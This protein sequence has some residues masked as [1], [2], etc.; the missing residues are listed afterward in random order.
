MSTRAET[1]SLQQPKGYVRWVINADKLK[2]AD[3]PSPTLD[4][5]R[6]LSTTVDGQEVAVGVLAFPPQEP[7]AVGFW[8]K[9]AEK[10]GKKVS[11]KEELPPSRLRIEPPIDFD[12][13]KRGH[14][15]PI[16]ALHPYVV[17]EDGTTYALSVF[18]P[19]KWIE[20]EWSELKER[21][22]SGK[23][24]ESYEKL[25]TT[26]VYRQRNSVA[27]LVRLNGNIPLAERR[28]EA[29]NKNIPIRNEM[30]LG[31]NE[32]AEPERPYIVATV[33]KRIVRYEN[34]SGNSQQDN[35]E[36]ESTEV[37]DLV[38]NV[39]AEQGTKENATLDNKG[40]VEV[41][42]V[43]CI[44]DEVIERII[45][46]KQYS[47]VNLPRTNS[48]DDLAMRGLSL[49]VL[50]LESSA[51]P[52]STIKGETRFINTRKESVSIISVKDIKPV[53]LFRLALVGSGGP[54]TAPMSEAPDPVPQS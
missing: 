41:I 32:E 38:F 23:L 40:L 37:S 15:T 26:E 29:S 43:R 27:L 53:A 12:D 30:L 25:G 24:Y 6:Y 31:I 52:D 28:R 39:V 5:N 3:L 19:K 50:K 35:G 8:A 36:T 14:H 22:E 51:T 34:G 7:R 47:K 2:E 42:V 11:P 21:P 45:K 17:M 46:S 1:E 48:H 10:V 33:G 49:D 54:I 9:I 44:D 20:K 16:S 18:L 4:N 13:A